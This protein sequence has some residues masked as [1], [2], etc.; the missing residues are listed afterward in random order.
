MYMSC[1]TYYE[2]YLGDNCDNKCDR[3]FG[4]KEI[5][6]CTQDFKV[7]GETILDEVTIKKGEWF[8]IHFIN[9]D[10]VI[11]KDPTGNF[12]RLNDMEIFKNNFVC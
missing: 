4:D 12:L 9:E 1:E 3:C 8:W 2:H 7:S 11:L 10:H 6:I 5:Y